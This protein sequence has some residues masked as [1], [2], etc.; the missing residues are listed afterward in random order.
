MS[1]W[2]WGYSLGEPWKSVTW[3]TYKVF[4]QFLDNL[5]V[6]IPNP[7]GATL[8]PLRVLR[9][10]RWRPRWPP[11][12]YVLIFWSQIVIKSKC[13][14][15][16]ICYLCR[17]MQL[18][19]NGKPS[20]D[21]WRFLVHFKSKWRPKG[22]FYQISVSN[23]HKITMFPRNY[24]LSVSRNAIK[25]EWNTLHGYLERCLFFLNQNGWQDGGQFRPKWSYYQH[26][27]TQIDVI[28][29][30]EWWQ[31]NVMFIYKNGHIV[32]VLWCK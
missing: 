15:T 18:K 10:S 11:M 2:K 31:A 32:T 22:I 14:P 26:I 7:P 19:Q 30:E 27:F 25:T 5:R 9:Y 13:C 1:A 12:K 17:G 6:L 20:M 16:T 23:C 4:W 21:I 8:S 28:W 29:V 24:M 3:S